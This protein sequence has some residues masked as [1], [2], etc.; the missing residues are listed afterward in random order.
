M[1]W[2]EPQSG[3]VA[4]GVAGAPFSVNNL[5][6]GLG[7][8]GG[9]IDPRRALFGNGD[10]GWFASSFDKFTKQKARLKFPSTQGGPLDVEVA[11][12]ALACGGGVYAVWRSEVRPGDPDRGLY[13][14]S[15]LRLPDAGL[16]G[17]GPAGEIGYKPLYQ[18]NGPSI[19]R[20]PDGQEWQLTPGSAASLQLLG[21]GRA[22]WMQGFTVQVA[23]LP[24]PAYATAGGIW[25]AQAVFVANAWWICYYSGAYGIVLHPFSSAERCYVILS[26]GDGWHRIV[27]MTAQVVRVAVSRTEGE[28]PGDVWGYDID[29]TTGYA[30]PLPFGAQPAEPVTLPFAPM[31][32]VDEQPVALPAFSFS[33]PLLVVPF[34]DPRGATKAK[35][36]ILVNQNDQETARPVFVADDTLTAKWRGELLGIYAEGTGAKNAIVEAE[37]RATRVLW[38]HDSDAPFLLPDGLR[39][40]DIPLVE[41]YRYKAHG[42]TLPAAVE[43]W[44]RDVGLMLATWKG[45]CGLVPQ[46]YCMGGAPP[47]EVLTVAEVLATQDYLSELANRSARIKILAP[48]SYLRANGIEPH[49]ELEMSFNNLL[50]AAPPGVAL[51][52][53]PPAHQPQ[54]TPYAAARPYAARTT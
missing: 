25:N 17:V 40:W 31:N 44:R 12:N 52:P 23:G 24:P 8:T 7:G 3:D 32:G 10:D 5:R 18:S 43:R 15:G 21:A 16:L 37:K 11:A 1:P 33:H 20:E 38:C 2:I 27:G 4:Q 35:A 36:E 28:A 6:E 30:I 14:S 19:V 9:W 53:V 46:F 45:D 50:V 26:K 22:I 13:A 49:V 51:T 34:K 48:F 29:V 47:N 42:E 54:A 39:P 41:L